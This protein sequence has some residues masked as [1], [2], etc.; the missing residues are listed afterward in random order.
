MN[1][2]RAATQ[3]EQ[4]ERQSVVRLQA[5]ALRQIGVYAAAAEI[6]VANKRRRGGEGRQSGG[7]LSSSVD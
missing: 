6:R 5:Q 3:Q 4:T 1:N 7:S 2:N